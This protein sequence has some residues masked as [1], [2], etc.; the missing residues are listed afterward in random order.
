MDGESKKPGVAFWATA[1]VVV[2]LAGF[3]GG[4]FLGRFAAL[5]EMQAKVDDILTELRGGLTEEEYA[6]KNEDSR[7]LLGDVLEEIEKRRER[8]AAE[9]P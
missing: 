5:R 4:Y 7:A 3:S 6:K 1:V 9:S 8:R 2:G